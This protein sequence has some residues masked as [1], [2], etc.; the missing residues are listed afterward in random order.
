MTPH[1]E[2]E[3][4]APELGFGG[5]RG[6][7]KSFGIF[8][9]VTLDDCQRLPGSKWLYLRKIGKKAQEQ[10]IDLVDAVLRHVEHRLTQGMVRFPNGS[11]VIIGHFNN[12]NEI[13]NYLGLEYDGIIV[14]ET[15]TLQE[16]VYKALR[17]AVRS[18]KMGWR[19]RI[20]NS[21]NPLGVGH[22]WYKKRFIDHERKN[23]EVVDRSRK[24]LF[25]TV[26]DNLFVN[27]DY[28][29]N[30]D[31]MTGAELRAYRFGDWDVSAGAYFDTWHYDRHVIDPFVPSGPVW[32]S[33]DYGFQHWNVIHLHTEGSDGAHF[34][35]DE[36]CL[37]KHYPEEIAPLFFDR[38]ADYGLRVNQLREFLA[39][40]DLWN[41]TGAAKK[42]IAEQYE[43]LGIEL[44][45]AI[46]DA[47]SRIA[48]A[49]HMAKLLGNPDRR[50]PPRWFVTSNCE[51][52]IDTIPFLERDPNNPEDVLKVDTDENGQ[53]GDDAYDCARYGL[54]REK[55]RRLSVSTRRWA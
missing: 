24:F 33:M 23:P 18:S 9:Q 30:L 49:H 4:G 10:L 39:G 37:R 47:G 46:T 35:F 12:E 43:A 21:T 15:T 42:S 11:R 44:K 36:L 40:A 1:I 3:R 32:A 34:T 27:P 22:Q 31:D 41:K 20:Y 28:V 2:G 51:R 7:G 53:G 55:V 29:G 6:P 45:A 50:I 25:A 26:D 48:G 16:R 52:L 5:A 19:P 8:G 17:A 13:F 54:F 14:E 38:L